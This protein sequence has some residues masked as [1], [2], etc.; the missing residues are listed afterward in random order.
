MLLEAKFIDMRGQGYDNGSNMRGCYRGVQ[1]RVLAENQRAAFVPCAC[2]TYNL[3]IGD[4]ASS[5]VQSV[6]LFGI[7]QR[8]FTLFSASTVRW[9]ILKKHVKGDAFYLFITILKL[10]ELI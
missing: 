8:L 4:A 9:E 5:S 3:V 6:T 10:E 2:H 1:A 7:I